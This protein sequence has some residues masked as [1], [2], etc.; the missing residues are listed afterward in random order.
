[1]HIQTHVLSGWCLGNLV[2]QLGPRERVMC[3]LAAS[4]ADVDGLGIVVSEE[5]YWDL[6]HKLGHCA[7]FGLLMSGALAMLSS[8]GRRWL[9][10]GV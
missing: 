5:L 1:M 4:L 8:R 10:F 9:A 6:H 2:P 7:A 3:M